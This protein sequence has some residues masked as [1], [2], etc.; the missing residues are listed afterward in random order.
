MQRKRTE[1]IKKK[2]YRIL[3]YVFFKASLLIFQLCLVV[4]WR[5]CALSACALT[6]AIIHACASALYSAEVWAISRLIISSHWTLVWVSAADE[7]LAPSNLETSCSYVSAVCRQLRCVYFWDNPL[8]VSV[9]TPFEKSV[10]ALPSVSAIYL[11]SS[12]VTFSLPRQ[13]KWFTAIPLNKD[14]SFLSS[15][16]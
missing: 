10:L 3:V 7:L 13:K 16:F 8:I 9:P 2:I 6:W 14:I 4:W 5:H 11:E 1:Q 15:I 12:N